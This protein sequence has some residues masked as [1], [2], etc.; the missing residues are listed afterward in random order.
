MLTWVFEQSGRIIYAL[1]DCPHQIQFRFSKQGMDHNVQD[2]PGSDMVGWSG[3]WKQAGVQES[4]GPVSGRT[5]PVRYQFPTFKLGSSTN[6]Q[7]HIV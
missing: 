1:S 2:R 5:Q 3:F 6:V 7:D 4:W